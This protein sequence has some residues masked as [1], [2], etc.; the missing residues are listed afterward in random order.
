MSRGIIHLSR[1]AWLALCQ[2]ADLA[3]LKIEGARGN[4]HSQRMMH[5]SPPERNQSQENG[6]SRQVSCSFNVA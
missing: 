5:V 6:K 2:N 3:Y 1:E 4:Y